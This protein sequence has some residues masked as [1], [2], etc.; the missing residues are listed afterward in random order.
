MPHS[1]EEMSDFKEQGSKE[2]DHIEEK[3]G[4]RVRESERGKLRPKRGKRE[5]GRSDGGRERR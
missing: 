5:E 1:R 2:R 4:R 3:R